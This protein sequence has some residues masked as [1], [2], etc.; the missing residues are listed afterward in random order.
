M[1]MQAVGTRNLK[2][3]VY[4][5]QWKNEICEHREFK[6]DTPIQIDH[7]KYNE[8]RMKSKTQHVDENSEDTQ[9]EAFRI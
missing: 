7:P 1:L 9:F 5:D 3:F 8:T 4:E 6:K 2:L